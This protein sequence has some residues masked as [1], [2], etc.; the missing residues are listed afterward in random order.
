MEDAAMRFANGDQRGAEAGLLAALRQP[1]ALETT[2]KGWIAAL[3]DFYRATHNQV[4]FLVRLPSLHV[5]W[6]RPNR[7]GKTS[8]GALQGESKPYR[9]GYL[10]CT[11]ALGCSSNGRRTMPCI[12]TP[13]PGILIGVHWNPSPKMP[14]RSWRVCTRSIELFVFAGGAI[15][16]I[17]LLPEVLSNP[18]GNQQTST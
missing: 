11:R 8:G 15:Q 18:D 4:G 1:R 16:L 7:N 10:E 12:P 17:P 9:G 13:C 3:L 2:A 6:G 14:C 5:I